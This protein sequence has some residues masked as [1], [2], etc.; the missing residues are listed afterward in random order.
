M[1]P[2]RGTPVLEDGLVS[3]SRCKVSHMGTESR[4]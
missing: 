2:V 4:H 1:V 3:Q